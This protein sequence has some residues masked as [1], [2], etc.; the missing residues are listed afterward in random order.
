MKRF[1]KY[2]SI[3]V[4]ILIIFTIVVYDR[5]ELY[6][7]NSSYIQDNTQ[8]ES[9]SSSDTIS[10]SMSD[11]SLEVSEDIIKSVDK[12]EKN[13]IIEKFKS[14]KE[15]FVYKDSIKKLNVKINNNIKNTYKLSKNVKNKEYVD[16]I[17]YIEKQD[18]LK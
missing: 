16:T 10:A 4:L 5:M 15:I 11:S 1:L 6:N 17:I 8:I 7:L 13:A 14:K 3:T 12:I 2:I 18:S 9:V